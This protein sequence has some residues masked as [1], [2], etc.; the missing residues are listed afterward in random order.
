MG[1]VHQKAAHLFDGDKF[2]RLHALRTTL[3]SDAVAE[4]TAHEALSKFTSTKF[5]SRFFF[6][7]LLTWTG[8][9]ANHLLSAAL[10]GHNDYNELSELLQGFRV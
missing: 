4:V 10:T 5:K 2:S 1:N 6:E 7:P 3:G 8:K 9:L